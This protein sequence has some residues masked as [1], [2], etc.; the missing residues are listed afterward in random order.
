[1]STDLTRLKTLPKTGDEI[2]HSANMPLACSLKDFWIWS[3]SDLVSNATRGRLAEFIVARALDIPSG[4]VRDEWDAYDLKMP[5]GL[6]IQV[7]SAAY[8]QSWNQTKL[9]PII[10]SIRRSRFWDADTNVQEEE[11]L[12]H[13]DLYVFAVL[14]HK[15]KGTID[16]LNVTQWEFYVLSKKDLEGYKR[17]EVSITLNSL[18]G[19][20]AGP[21]DYFGLAAKV[22]SALA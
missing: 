7:K 20:K 9:S 11:P 8:V 18:K 13:S 17:S 6:K 19:L 1:M 14:A 4:A 2:F 16:P 12:R 5:D 21:V 10:F 3:V 15:E 22:K